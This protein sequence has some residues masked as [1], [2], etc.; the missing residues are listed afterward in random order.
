M[1]PTTFNITQRARIIVWIIM[2]RQDPIVAATWS[3]I[4]LLTFVW[5]LVDFGQVYAPLAAA[6]VDTLQN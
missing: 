6:E 5:L 2:K 3:A 1:T 4:F